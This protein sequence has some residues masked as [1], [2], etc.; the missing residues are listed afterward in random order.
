MTR[1]AKELQGRVH[2][3]VPRHPKVGWTFRVKG[4]VSSEAAVAN[5]AIVF[6][7]DEGL[8]YAVDLS[9]RRERWRVATKDSVEAAPAIVADHVFAGSNDKTFRALDLT[10]GRELWQVEGDEKFPTGGVPVAGPDG[11][12]WILVNGYDGISRCLRR[13]DGSLV[14]KHETQDYV[15]GSPAILD[16]GLLAYGA[17]DALIHIIQLKDGIAANQV[18]SDAQII[19]SL[20]ASGGTVYGVNHA[21]QLIATDVKADKPKWLYESDDTP[22]LTSPGV[23]EERVYV[24]ARDKQVHAVDR[25]SGKPV[26]KFKTGGRVES[27]PLVFDD[28]VVF[29]SSDGRLYAVNK[30]DGREIWKLDLGE[31]LSNA[32]AFA[33]GRIVIGGGDGTLFIIEE[34]P[35][36]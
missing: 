6:G 17:C 28:A 16:A 9:T 19:R 14:W 8:I 22:F 18:T 7:S 25:L 2:D 36:G 34:G 31:D 30:Q 33:D 32:P 29:G 12:E 5:G 27:S 20:A 24:G 1:G 35:G 13:K 10:I 21:N 26:W 4:A 23:D 3:R 11:E 15:N